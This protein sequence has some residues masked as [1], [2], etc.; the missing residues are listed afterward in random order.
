LTGNVINEV[1]G[2][3]PVERLLRFAVE[4]GHFDRVEKGK[5]PVTVSVSV[6]VKILKWE[7]NCSHLFYISASMMLTSLPS[8]SVEPIWMAGLVLP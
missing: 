8:Q 6:S 7:Q 2:A 5:K 4:G 1:E 3:S